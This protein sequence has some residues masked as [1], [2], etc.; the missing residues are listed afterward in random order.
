MERIFPYLELALPRQSFIERFEYLEVSAVLYSSY[1]QNSFDCEHVHFY[2]YLRFVCIYIILFNL[3]SFKYLHPVCACVTWG[4]PFYK[5]TV[6]SVNFH[7]TTTTKQKWKCKEHT[8]IQ[9]LYD[10]WPNS[11]HY[12]IIDERHNWASRETRER[13][14]L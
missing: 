1:L 5:V 7:W 9:F 12:V 3:T 4:F 10:L 14:V 11:V 2:V 8:G 13:K 6:L